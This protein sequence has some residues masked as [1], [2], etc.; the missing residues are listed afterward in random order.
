LTKIYEVRSISHTDDK[1]HDWGA[2]RSRAE[3]EILLA[4]RFTGSNTDWANRYHKRWW[5]EELD[6]TGSFV[7][8]PKPTPRERFSTKVTEIPGEGETWGTIHVDILDSGGQVVAAYDR[9]YPT[10]Y[11]T[12]E[13]F[14]QA[15]RSFALISTDYTATSVMDLSSGQI[16]AAEE[17]HESGFCPVGFYVP[18]W[19]DINSDHV[20]PGSSSWTSDYEQ[21]DGTFGF[22]WGCIWGDDSSWK[23]QYLDLSNVRD[24]KILRDDRFG[25]VKLATLPDRHPKN[26]IHCTFYNGGRAVTFSVPT[27]FDLLTGKNLERNEFE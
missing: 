26:F 12:F 10:L 15:D 7:I 8:P 23:V 2:R 18:D 22:V 4:E 27:K 5:I 3:A 20:L 24:G 1:L 16:I 11:E 14:R 9:N 6:T 19:W 17:P 13:P 25:Y 21:P